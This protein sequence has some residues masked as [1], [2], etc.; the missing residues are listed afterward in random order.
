ML[1]KVQIYVVRIRAHG[2]TMEVFFDRSPH[3]SEVI[4][5]VREV[6]HNSL[7]PEVLEKIYARR[8]AI[9]R[10]VLVKLGS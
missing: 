7:H 1:N 8:Y 10:E 5:A 9:E 2:G 6:L 4:E 3:H